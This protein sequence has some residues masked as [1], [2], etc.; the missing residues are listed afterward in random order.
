MVGM[1]QGLLQ[2]EIMNKIVNILLYLMSSPRGI[3]N[4]DFSL[5]WGKL[6]ELQRKVCFFDCFSHN[7]FFFT[8]QVF[9]SI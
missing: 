9:S 7:D 8:K 3:D 5:L 4:N 1:I 6:N 2:S